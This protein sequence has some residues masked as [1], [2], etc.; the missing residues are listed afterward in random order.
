LST[1][2]IAG[3]GKQ[4]EYALIQRLFK[5]IE[6]RR[7]VDCEFELVQYIPGSRDQHRLISLR[8]A[9]CGH[10]IWL[11]V[12]TPQYESYKLRHP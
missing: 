7:K 8:Y 3:L 12:I 2:D 6:R 11:A 9:C 5:A 10:L 4:V 1:V